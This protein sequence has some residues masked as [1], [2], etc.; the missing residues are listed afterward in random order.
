MAPF[1]DA[2]D[3]RRPWSDRHVFNDNGVLYL[4]FMTILQCSDI[5]VS[6]RGKHVFYCFTFRSLLHS[7]RVKSL[8]E[9][10]LPEVETNFYCAN[11]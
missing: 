8:I 11:L 9:L 7:S 5:N 2:E 10:K 4:W 1:R 3:E 6:Y